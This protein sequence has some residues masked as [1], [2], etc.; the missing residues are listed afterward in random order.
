MESLRARLGAVRARGDTI[1][2]VPTM[3][4]L[5]EG[6]LQLVDAARARAP[7]VVVSIFVNPLQFGPTEDF[8][9]YPRTLA[10]DAAALA[11]RDV[12]VLFAPTVNEM[13][14]DGPKLATRVRV[15][16]LGDELCGAS[17]P[18][19]FEGV[20]TVVAKLFNIVQPDLA[21]FGDKDRQQLTVIRRMVR[22]L[23][24]ALEI[25]GV[26]TVRAADGLALS[27][28]NGYLDAD[29]RARAPVLY[30]TLLATAERMTAAPG[31]I[32]ELE[33]EAEARLR[34]AGFEPDYVAIRRIHDLAPPQG[35]DRE[36][37]VLAAARL[38][39]TRLIDNHPFRL[40]APLDAR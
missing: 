38:G 10:A 23:S 39:S 35:G 9:A 34:E 28:R 4:N 31:P 32:T 18:G 13:Y 8:E 40:G 7:C 30:A 19:H 11:G 3:G 5:H 2:L 12:A 16:G 17:R 6:H 24:M 26:P 27:S 33:A 36:L 29:A 25:V 14:P 37:V 21:V 22:D 15:D 1:A 20:A